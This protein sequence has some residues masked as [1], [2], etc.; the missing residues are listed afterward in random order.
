MLLILGG[1]QR[2]TNHP[3]KDFPGGGTVIAKIE[4]LLGKLIPI[5]ADIINIFESSYYQNQIR[6]ITSETTKAK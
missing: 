6:C 1:T 2:M 4:R 3:G 5:L